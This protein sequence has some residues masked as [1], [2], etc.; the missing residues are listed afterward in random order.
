MLEF[1][2]TRYRKDKIMN[3]KYAVNYISEE[4]YLDGEKISETKREYVNGEVWAMAGASLAHNILTSSVSRYFGNHLEGTRCTA[5]SSDLKVKAD[6]NFFYPDIVV[7]CSDENNDDY[8]TDKPLLIVEV[9]S[10]STARFDKTLKMVSYKTLSSLQEYVLIEQDFA[11]IMVCRR[12]NNWVSEYFFLGDDVTFESIGLTIAVEAIYQRV[13][14]QD[15]LD[16]FQ[17]KAQQMENETC[18]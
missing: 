18:Q 13:K 4:D 5:V 14:N 9:L 7:L 11:E 16:Y 17:Q 8:Y 3:L 1:D 15:V 10:K 12:N 2:K 6:H